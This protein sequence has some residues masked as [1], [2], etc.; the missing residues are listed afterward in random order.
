MLLCFSLSAH[1][2]SVCVHQRSAAIP[3]SNR[4][5]LIINVSPLMNDVLG[6]FILRGRLSA[7][8]QQTTRGPFSGGPRL[9]E[10]LREPLY[11]NSLLKTY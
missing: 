8:I 7:D 3:L 9:R 5:T 11:I 6:V 4:F 10:R 1:C 2:N